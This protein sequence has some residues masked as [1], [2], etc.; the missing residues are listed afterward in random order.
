MLAPHHGED[1]QLREI[2]LT[3][4][5]FFDPL[6]LIGLEPVLGDEL[7]GNGGIGCNGHAVRTLADVAKGSTRETFSAK[8]R[9]RSFVEYQARRECL[10]LTGAAVI[11]SGPLG[12]LERESRP[13]RNI[14]NGGK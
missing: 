7:R 4:E 11:R 14:N 6:V 2:R 1:A 13:Q 9:D 3:T 8:S 10:T 12:G 5:D